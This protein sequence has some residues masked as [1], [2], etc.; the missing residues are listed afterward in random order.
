MAGG[1]P[2]EESGLDLSRMLAAVLRFKWVIVLTTIL[3]GAGGAAAW[4]YI[5]FDYTADASLWIQEAPNTQ[6]RGDQGPISGSQLL[7]SSS[8]IDLL[9]SFAVLNTVVVTEGLYLTVQDSTFTPAFAGFG[10][11]DR[12]VPGDYEVLYSPAAESVTL[13]REGTVVEATA[14]GE[15]V[16][17][18]VGFDW[19][20]AIDALAP[21]LPV[22]FTVRAPRD[23]AIELERNLET[24]IDANA[25]FIRVRLTGATPEGVASTLNAILE[26]QVELA[27]ELKT[28]SL[29]ERTEVLAGQL[30]TVERE[31]VE[32]E[33]ALELFRVNTIAL[34]SDAAMP[35]Q[36]GIQFTQGPAFQTYNSLKLQIEQLRS[37]RA[38]MER[39][40][41][42][43]PDSTL[44]VEALEAIPEVQ[45][46]SQLVAALAE[47]TDA[48]VR[49]RGLRQRFTD[50]YIAVQDVRQEVEDLE[51][52]TIPR[53]LMALAQR[54]TDDEARLQDR[55]DQA[56]QELG[57]IP[58]R[59]IEEARLERRVALA[60]RLFTELRG[61][62][63]EASLA[64]LSSVPDVRILDRAVPPTKPI[65]DA[66]LRALLMFI[67]GG[68][69]AGIGLAILLDR[70]DARVQYASD[71][72]A[73]LGLDILGVVP[74]MGNGKG[75]SDQAA[76][77]AVE[78]FRDLRVNV[79]FA[80][81]AGRPL[82][83][84]LTSPDQSEGKSTVTANLAVGFASVGRRT[85]VIDGDTR[86][87][88]LHRMLQV[89]RKPGLTDFLRDDATLVEAVQNTKFPLVDIIASGSRFRTSPELLASGKI[90][91]LLGELWKRYDVILVDSPPLGAGADALILG[92]LTGQI[93]LILRTGQTN[94]SYAQAKLA[95]LERLPIRMLGVILNGFVAGR[96][97]GYYAYSEYI[98][99]YEATDEADETGASVVS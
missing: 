79:E 48:R 72:T 11:A 85:L 53:L 87:G 26:R 51:R 13:S 23:V 20:P 9:R 46:S 21:D 78:A 63:Q 82:A 2:E 24:R 39:V 27:A 95:G 91:E 44:R 84:T 74:V 99:G 97:Q 36:G 60:N 4:K 1:D 81:G 62:Y 86:K 37:N 34:P 31:L 32:S 19:T 43:L 8:W 33:R 90:G 12:F 65:V 49:L 61:R 68:L 35:I 71:V 66:R 17:A 89:P 88:D 28:A 96:A 18:P 14:S 54:I 73:S 93:G 83:I 3:G 45:S 30:A 47:L 42:D 7:R 16:G 80:Y 10:L 69:G 22:E 98:D 52:V 58:P 15:Q 41:A 38:A 55:I 94:M 75:S 59:S 76:R 40:L 57:D 56:T 5:E 25:A 70:L 92:T 6:Q 64:S 50:E 29:Q 77:N 67:V